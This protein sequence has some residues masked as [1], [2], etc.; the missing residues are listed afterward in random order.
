MSQFS[1]RHLLYFVFRFRRQQQNPVRRLFAAS[2]LATLMIGFVATVA[3]SED[4]SRLL[5]KTDDDTVVVG[6]RFYIDVFVDAATPVNAVDVELQYPDGL[7]D[8]DALRVGE[9]VL[10]I[11]TEPP[12][13]DDGVITLRGGTFRRGFSGQHRIMSIA[14]RATAPGVIRLRPEDVTF[15]AGDGTGDQVRL[16]VRSHDTLRVY[17]V[18]ESDIDR[19]RIVGLDSTTGERL[20]DLN[21]SG[22]VTMQ[23]ISIFMAAWNDRS[24][25]YDFN[26]DGKMT[27]RDFS[28]LLADFFR[29]R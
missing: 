17:A 24:I 5:L 13:A 27:F 15:L 26:G 22:G 14:A 18:S 20:T 12:A 6:E 3:L 9:S 28:I 4:D 25:V 10:T 1:F 8:V 16:D 7:L 2:F 23:D 11:W 19:P 29:G 21:G